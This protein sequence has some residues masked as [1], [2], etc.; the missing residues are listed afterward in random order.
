MNPKDDASMY[1]IARIELYPEKPGKGA[2]TYRGSCEINPDNDYYMEFY[3]KLL[4]SFEQYQEAV[5]VY[6]KLIEAN[7]YNVDY[8]NQL[9]RFLPFRW[10]T[11]RCNRSL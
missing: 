4:N 3:G 5:K 7:P 2:S 10:K 9:G 6:K 1:E 8:Y 11:R